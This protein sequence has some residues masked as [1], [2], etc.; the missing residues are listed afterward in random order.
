M[1]YTDGFTS[2]AIIKGVPLN[3]T[4]LAKTH[5]LPP[6]VRFVTSQYGITSSPTGNMLIYV[7]MVL[8]IQHFT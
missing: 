8:Q 7:Y 6:L 3:I 5:N 4:E 1:I 2:L